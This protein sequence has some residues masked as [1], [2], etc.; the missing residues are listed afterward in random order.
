M[1]QQQGMIVDGTLNQSLP[2][3]TRIDRTSNV[4]S[5]QSERPVSLKVGQLRL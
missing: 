2:A 3:G 5:A 1:M 4:S